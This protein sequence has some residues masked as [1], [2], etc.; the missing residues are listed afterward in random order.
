MELQA[1]VLK[2]DIFDIWVAAI[3]LRRVELRLRLC[4]LSCM[5]DVFVCWGN[6][7][8]VVPPWCRGVSV[9]TMTGTSGVFWKE[10]TRSAGALQRIYIFQRLSSH[11]PA[12]FQGPRLMRRRTRFAF[13]FDTYDAAVP[14]TLNVAPS[15]QR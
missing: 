15:G 14:P 10:K 13:Y 7:Q 6:I 9:S 8:W 2:V 4:Q 3:G 11:H 5:L 1:S 12:N